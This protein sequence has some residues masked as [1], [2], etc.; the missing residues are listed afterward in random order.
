M[1]CPGKAAAVNTH[2]RTHNGLPGEQLEPY[3]LLKQ[4]TCQLKLHSL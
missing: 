3:L 4:Y 1:Y 2:G